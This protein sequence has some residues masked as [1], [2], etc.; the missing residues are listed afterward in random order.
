MPLTGE[1]EPSTSDWAREQA[2][3]FMESGGTEATELNGKPIILLTTVGAKS[4]KLRKTPLMRVEYQGEYAVVASLGGA[5]KHPVWYH[6][7]KKNP[8]VEL[9]DQTVTKEYDAREVFG[10]EKAEWW[11][12]AV[13]VWPDYADYQKKTDREIPVFVLTPVE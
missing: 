12:R 7:I 8:R 6:N 1:Y 2:E 5:P 11:D 13:E 10:E 4:G 9:Q 3:K